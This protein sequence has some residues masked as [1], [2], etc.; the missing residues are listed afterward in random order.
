[1]ARGYP[2]FFGQQQ[3]PSYG[4]F[5][6][7]EGNTLCT[8]GAFTDIFEIVGKG[9]LYTAVFFTIE[10]V[11]SGDPQFKLTIDDFTISFAGNSLLRN[12]GIFE[13]ANDLITLLYYDKPNQ[14]YCWQIKEGLTFGQSLKLSGFPNSVDDMLITYRV[15][16]GNVA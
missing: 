1:M 11:V 15:S 16:Y 12:Y 6:I 4:P 9:R 14:D 7:L 10:A 5:T 13:Q 2:D 3:F 8:A